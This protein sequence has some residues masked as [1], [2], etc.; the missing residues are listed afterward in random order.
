MLTRRLALAVA[1]TV[2]VAL[3]SMVSALQFAGWEWVAL[4]LST[5]V[6]FYSGAG[7]HRAALRSARHRR[8]TM[9]TL[10]SLGTLAAWSWSTVVA[11]RRPRRGHLL[12]GRGRR[13][14]ADPARP[15]PRGP[16]EAPFVARRSGRCSSSAPR[17]RASC[18]TA[19]RSSFPSPTLEVGDLFVVRPG[20]KIATDGVVVEGES[21]IDRSMLTG[22]PVPVEVG[23]R[24]RG[25][26][27]RP[28]NT[29]GAPRRPRDE[30]RRRHGARAHRA[31]R[32][33]G[34]V[35]Q[36]AGAA[37]RRPRLGGLRPGR[38]RALAR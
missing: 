37:A 13:D 31:P 16:R 17:R 9:D 20:E 11:R 28:L 7:F 25:R 6:V 22:E 15:V 36:G 10:I 38:D 3:L 24:I 12:R 18:A 19:G 14:D 30:G 26:P 1:L 27:A 34:A 8:A 35:R 29:Y 5:P 33:A 2:P 21:A 23:R 4:A 32:R